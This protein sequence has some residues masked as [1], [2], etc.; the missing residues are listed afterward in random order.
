[1]SFV[2]NYWNL[3]CSV[4]LC[5]LVLRNSRYY[6]RGSWW[7]ACGGVQDCVGREDSRFQASWKSCKCFF[8]LSFSEARLSITPLTVDDRQ[9]PQ[10]Q[11]VV[12]S[13]FLW[14]NA[15]EWSLKCLAGKWMMTSSASGM[16]ADC[17]GFHSHLVWTMPCYVSNFCWIEQEVQKLDISQGWCWWSG[18][19]YFSWGVINA[20]FPWS[21]LVIIWIR[22]HLSS[23]GCPDMK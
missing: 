16:W 9:L 5:D 20:Q 23:G 21:R 8:F 17:G 19:K 12:I 10:L 3:I 15:W 22:V 14:K 11:L 7:C 1:M 4:L 2:G 13:L 6:G 18:G